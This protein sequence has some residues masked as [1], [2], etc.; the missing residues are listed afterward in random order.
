MNIFEIENDKG[1]QLSCLSYQNSRIG[2]ILSDPF[3]SCN[4]YLKKGENM[5]KSILVL[6]MF[7]LTT[8]NIF[9]QTVE[10]MTEIPTSESREQ[11]KKSEKY[12]T[13]YFHETLID[14]SIFF[15]DSILLNKNRINR[16]DSR[17]ELYNDSR[18][19]LLYNI[20][21]E[22]VTKEDNE[23]GEMTQLTVQNSNE[24]FGKYGIVQVKG[25]DNDEIKDESIRFIL[26]DGSIYDFVIIDK[27]NRI[28]LV[29]K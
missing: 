23:T 12:R 19:I 27:N 28:I 9:C 3:T 10:I 29:K 4:Q 14:S 26:K 8:T 22:T 15:Q 16:E 18:F 25:T 11:K 24:I 21:L 13:Y 6:S 1:G 17:F 2:L 5:K 7:V 20:K